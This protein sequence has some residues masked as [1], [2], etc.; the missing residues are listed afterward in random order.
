LLHRES[1]ERL[2][3]TVVE[4]LWA[5]ATLDP[6][7]PY[8]TLGDV[9]REVAGGREWP[10]LDVAL[11]RLQAAGEVARTEH[12]LRWGH[13][14]GAL[15]GDDAR[16]AEEL[17]TRFGAAG[18]ETPGVAEA[19]AAVGLPAKE[20]LRLLQALERQ[21]RMVKVGED[22]Y[23]E[24]GNLETVMARISGAMEAVGQLTLAQVRDLLGTSRKY[25]Q[26]LVEHM[27]SEGLTLRVGDARRLRRRR[28]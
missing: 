18:A 15:E 7:D 14:P 20:G 11:E 3:G 17:L 8:L 22:F 13:A 12:G 23:Y 28:R 19:A 4:L 1:L 21:G 10:A 27:D 26:A 9:R 5:R 24:S 6:L 25:A 16:L 2:E